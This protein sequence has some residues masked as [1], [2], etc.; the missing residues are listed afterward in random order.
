MLDLPNEILLLI[1]DHLTQAEDPEPDMFPSLRTFYY[2]LPLLEVCRQWRDLFFTKVYRSLELHFAR[3]QLYLLARSLR[4]NPRMGTSIR[5]LWI[6]CLRDWGSTSDDEEK[7]DETMDPDDNELVDDPTTKPFHDL[8]EKASRDQT[9]RRRWQRALL[10]GSGDAWMAICFYLLPNLQ[11]FTLE[12]LG[13]PKTWI[14]LA[15]SRIASGSIDLQPRPL[16]HLEEVIIDGNL[17]VPLLSHL[18]FFPYFHLPS[19]RS[20]RGCEITELREGRN[21]NIYKMLNPRPSPPE[22]Q[23]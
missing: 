2:T 19:M 18:E 15:L 5:R 13:R 1:F 7:E 12:Y 3:R 20:F 23:N 9:E 16:Q 21:A 11:S 17:P 4:E 10:R 6:E 22:S 14:P 8:L